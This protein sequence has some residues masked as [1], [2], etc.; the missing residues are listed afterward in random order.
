MASRTCDADPLGRRIGNLPATLEPLERRTLLSTYAL[1]TLLSAGGNSGIAAANASL[2][3]TANDIVYGTTPRGGVDGAGSLFVWSRGQSKF[4]T[5]AYL[6]GTDGADPVGGLVMDAAG[7]LYGTT[8]YTTGGRTGNAPRLTGTLGAGDGTV[9]ELPKGSGTITPLATF[10]GANGQS[11][12]GTLAID[13]NGNLFG[14]TR[15]GGANGDGTVFEMPAGSGTIVTLASFDGANGSNPDAPLLLDSNGNLIGAT[16]SGG[17]NG[18]GTLFEIPAAGGNLTTLASF[19]GANGASPSSGLVEDAGGNLFGNAATG[20]ANNQGV[21][22]E[23]PAGS[24]AITPVASFDGTNGSD[25]QGQLTIDASGNL[26]GTA[27]LNGAADDGTVFEI[28]AGTGAITTIAAFSGANGALPNGLAADGNGNYFAMTG[29][30][31][32]YGLGTLDRLLLGG[33]ANTPGNFRAVMGQ[34]TLPAT[35]A[36]GELVDAT[37]I[38]GLTDAVPVNG[39]VTIRLYASADGAIDPSSTLIRTA[40]A[41]ES[42]K[43]GVQFAIEVPIVTLPAALAEGPYQLL[44]QASDAVGNVATT[45]TGPAFQVVAPATTYSG[46]FTRVTLPAQSVS[47]LSTPA[48]AS[49]QLASHPPQG[50][51]AVTLY[52]SPDGTVANGVAVRN[53]G[54]FNPFVVQAGIN[55]FAI[56]LLRIP[57]GLNG[58]YYLVAQL[59]GQTG[60]SATIVSADTYSIVPGAAAISAQVGTVRPATINPSSRAFGSILVTLTNT[61]DIA[62]GGTAE[63][64]TLT[65]GL[66]SPDGTQSVVIETFTSRAVL[67]PGRSRMVKLTFRQNV[68]AAASV[69]SGTWLP[70]IAVGPIAGSDAASATGQTPITVG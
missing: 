2:L 57:P 68:F 60:A 5:L 23:L 42:V 1:Q 46:V 34:A 59:N 51:V 18:D 44:A 39:P 64:F 20:G 35:V 30:G 62:A 31:G 63:P 16:R 14:T 38:V 8:V 58:S 29:S 50:L 17:A 10:N 24:G 70:T 61:G 6:P 43:A 53:T 48:R 25:P 26:F 22:Y 40:V 4:A 36:A 65:L 11:P 66:V 55:A 7:N 41:A 47:G 45:S 19:D 21:V 15:A 12:E 28:A 54:G 69:P 52:L 13:A 67:K 37:V 32:A 27:Q 49:I 9:F 56:P 33:T 3:V